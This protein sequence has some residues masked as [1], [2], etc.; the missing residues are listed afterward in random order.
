MYSVRGAPG[1]DMQSSF[2]NNKDDARQ[3]FEKGETLGT[4]KKSNNTASTATADA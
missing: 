2:H 3:S 4:D 1:N